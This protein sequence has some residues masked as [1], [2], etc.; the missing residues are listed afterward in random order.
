MKI[1]EK[2]PEAFMTYPFNTRETKIRKQWL[3]A[4][5]LNTLLPYGF[6]SLQ[7]LDSSVALLTAFNSLLIL[8]IPLWIYYRCA[9]QNPGTRFLLAGLIMGPLFTIRDL[10]KIGGEFGED[11][12]PW[13][14]TLTFLAPAIWFY[15]LSFK[16][17][18]INKKIQ[19]ENKSLD[20][21]APT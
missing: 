18:Q 17:R 1:S 3:I 12:I 19:K 6:L 8:A 15:V 9:Y 2:F 5:F 13:L 14:V 21:P 16:M 20:T 7:A 10:I 4:L 11:W